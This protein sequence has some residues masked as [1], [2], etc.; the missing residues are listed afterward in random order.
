MLLWHRLIPGLGTSA[1]HRHSRK[2]KKRQIDLNKAQTNIL[3]FILHIHYSRNKETVKLYIAHCV[4]WILQ[5]RKY[6][7]FLS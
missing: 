7:D 3:E 5:M 2:K 6:I 1:C 4:V